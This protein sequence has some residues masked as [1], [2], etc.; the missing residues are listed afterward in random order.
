MTARPRSVRDDGAAARSDWRQEW[1]DSLGARWKVDLAVLALI[2]FCFGEVRPLSD[3]DL[4]MHLAVGE[5]IVRHHTVPTVEPFA[6]T[7]I[8][9]PY[10][11][12]SWLP[13]SLFYVVLRAFGHLGLRLLHG[14][15]VLACACSMVVL[16]RAA[17]WRPSQAIIMAGLNVVV[18]GLF[19]AFLRP[20]TILLITLPLI[21][22]A[23]LWMTSGR[24]TKLAVIVLF[25][26][27]ALTAN[28]HIFF[29]L[30]LAPAA[31]L[32]VHPPARR[33]DGVLGVVSVVA[34]WF[35]SPYA[36]QWLGVFQL[37]FAPNLLLRPPSAITELQPGFVAMLYPSLKPM[38]ALVAAMLA[39]PWVSSRLQLTARERV[40]A[41]LYWALG[42]VLFGYAARLFVAWWLLAIVPVGWSVAY[43]TRDTAEGAPRFG[44][45]LFGLVACVAVLA[46]ELYVTRPLRRL[47]GDV[48]SRSL[49]THDA[50]PAEGIA[51]WIDSNTVAVADTRLMTNFSYGSYLT[52]RLPGYSVSIDSRAIFP[53]SVGAAEAVVGAAERDI[54]L[55]PWRSAEVAILPLRYRAA[56]ALDTASGWRRAA[57]VPGDPI[58]LDSTGLWVT[59]VWWRRHGKGND[60][61]PLSTKRIL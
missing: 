33:R 43:L 39:V 4:P 61:R 47:E 21:W 8:G 57:T 46:A 27:S 52:W 9:A 48:V 2:V 58:A 17:G 30:T 60:V 54:P 36:L 59:D 26:A 1:A 18:A 37:N 49:P 31:L 42:L 16:S 19:V 13:E 55:G 11:A 25:G 32:L 45:R 20:Q 56:A 12:Y 35:A 24:R 5:W 10:F 50:L 29:P 15:V 51:R 40:M 44:V 38:A 28:S 34:G 23:F 7:R 22:S 53:D 6:W 14:A 3:P 41:G